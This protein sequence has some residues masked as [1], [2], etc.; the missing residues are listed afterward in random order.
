MVEFKELSREHIEAAN[1]NSLTGSN[2]SATKHDYDVYCAQI[3]GFPVS[4]EKKQKIADKLYKFFSRGLWLAAQHASVAVAGASNYNAKK[5]DKSDQILKNSS[6][7]CEWWNSIKKQLETTAA[8]DT[9]KVKELRRSIIW[10]IEGGWSITDKWRQLAEISR[11]EFNA[12]Y[13]KLDEK[14]HFRKTSISYKIY[15]DIEHIEEKAKIIIC[16]NAD[17]KAYTEGSRAYIRFTLKPQR[18]LIVALKSRGWWWN[19]HDNV[20]STYLEKLDTEW[21]LSIGERYKDY[22]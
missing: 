5:L 1:R 6:E 12:L 19:A 8:Y 13:E 22:I 20:W 17:Y 7:F 3:G 14:A 18:Q 4:D 15:H 16:D 21:V 2:G 9:E 10:G 11:S